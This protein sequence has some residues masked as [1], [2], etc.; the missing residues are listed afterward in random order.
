LGFI[1]FLYRHLTVTQI[2][3]LGLN[4]LSKLRSLTTLYVN[5]V[6]SIS[7]RS[8]SNQDYINFLNKLSLRTFGNCPIKTVNE[9]AFQGLT[10]LQ[11]L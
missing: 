5:Y 3:V 2:T 1:E 4:V 6:A 10:N 11:E 8:I 7:Y 9:K